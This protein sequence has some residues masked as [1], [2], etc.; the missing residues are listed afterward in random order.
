MSLHVNEKQTV[1]GYPYGR[2]KCTAFFSIDFSK[3][4]GFR[5]IFQTINPKTGKLN[6]E[7]KST[8]SQIC[9]MKNDGGFITTCSLEFYKEES[10][11]RI[12]KF[13]SENFA[14]FTAEQIDYIYSLALAFVKVSVKSAIIYKGAKLEDVTPFFDSAIA[15]LVKG[16]N[17]KTN[18]FADI[19]VDFEG[20]N[21]KCDPNYN[22]FK[23]EKAA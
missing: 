5:H 8:Y 11:H 3:T 19:N 12:A 6:A 14:L 15:V 16:I 9:Y 21:S 10:L 17:E 23:I 7:K 18:V 1:E 22:A 13:M 20:V 2:L 4:K